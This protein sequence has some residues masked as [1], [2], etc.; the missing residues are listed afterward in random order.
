M[1]ASGCINKDGTCVQGCGDAR[2]ACSAPTQ[3]MLAAAMM[4]C[5][6]QEKAAAAACVQANPGGG[7]A[8]DQCLT[9]AQAN[10]FA[11]REAA[12]EAAGP[13]FAACTQQYLGCVKACPA[14]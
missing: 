4:A 2:D 11:C 7:S 12:L 8:L 14:A 1:T 13:G 6:A 3:S 5:T 10:A 9:T